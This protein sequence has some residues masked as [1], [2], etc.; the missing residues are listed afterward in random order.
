MMNQ[1]RTPTNTFSSLGRSRPQQQNKT[2]LPPIPLNT[3]A[4]STRNL[5]SQPDGRD[6]AV[7]S[8]L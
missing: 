8:A 7:L 5:A 1:L 2:Q 3:Q 6:F 4:P